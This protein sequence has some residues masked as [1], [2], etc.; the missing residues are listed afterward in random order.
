MKYQIRKCDTFTSTRTSEVATLD[1]EDFKSENIPENLQYTGDSE[2]EFIAY[3]KENFL[4][5]S[6][7]YELEDYVSA[8]VIKELG[9]IATPLMEEY[10][11]SA[12][13]GANEWIESGLEEPDCYE[14]GG[15]FVN[16][17]TNN[18]DSECNS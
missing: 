14:T 11:N 12:W 3:I 13:N 8:D 18:P 9:K 15:F 5:D 16:E 17:S 7:I 6:S 4:N 2:V 1:P 10:H